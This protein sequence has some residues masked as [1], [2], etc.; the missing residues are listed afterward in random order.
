M[1]DKKISELTAA[2]T[3]SGVELAG[4]QSGDNVRVPSSLIPV[5]PALHS[6][7]VSI[8]SAQS[9]PRN[10]V[11]KLTCLGQEDFDPS[12]YWNTSTQRFQPT[13]AG[14][15]LVSAK[16][17]LSTLDA[18]ARM[19]VFV[20]KNGADDTYMMGRGVPGAGGELGGFGGSIGVVMNGS[21]DYLTMAVFHLNAASTTMANFASYTSFTAT[22]VGPTS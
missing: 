19:V 21:T 10:V 17:T 8:N 3:L 9:I 7:V 12:N 1:V 6:V 22:Y 14:L 13:K 18:G 2:T 20:G 11:T 5:N 15:Y 16:A 4:T